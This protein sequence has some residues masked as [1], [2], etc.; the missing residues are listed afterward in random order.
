MELVVLM[1]QSSPPAIT[2]NIF[3]K[4]CCGHGHT[5]L[6]GGVCCWAPRHDAGVHDAASIDHRGPAKPDREE[7][8]VSS[9]KPSL[10]RVLTPGALVIINPLIAGFFVFRKV[11]MRVEQLYVLLTW[12]VQ[13]AISVS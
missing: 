12:S 3:L 5:T 9:T 13:L 11:D 1:T 4:I 7:R 2:G 6:S 8:T 10:N